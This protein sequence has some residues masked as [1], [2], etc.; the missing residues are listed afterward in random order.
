MILHLNII[1]FMLVSLALVHFIFP[2][3]FDWKNQLD[4]LGLINKQMVYVHTFFI[5]LMVLLMG[6][7]CIT[8]A[9]E[10]RH[11]K[12]GGKLCLGLGIFWGCRLVIQFVGYSSLLWRGKRFETI[13]HILFIF[14]WTYISL[15][16][17]MVYFLNK[18]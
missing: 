9:T 5:A 18:G 12:L 17:F 11:D 1:G 3:Y 13:V 15:V 4:K 2:R 7:L 14:L 16:F 8:S 6:V 10:L